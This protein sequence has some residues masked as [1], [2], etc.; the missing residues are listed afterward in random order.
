MGMELGTHVPIQDGG[1][2]TIHAMGDG[3]AAVDA[4][5]ARAFATLAPRS[6][7][8]ERRIPP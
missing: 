3:R 8:P 1:I 4:I 2:P 7:R 6:R 5:A